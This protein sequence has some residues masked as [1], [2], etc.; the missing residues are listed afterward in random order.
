[1]CSKR[2][3]EASE[4]GL[5]LRGEAKKRCSKRRAPPIQ[6]SSIKKW[7]KTN[8]TQ[9]Q[10]WS[11]CRLAAGALARNAP[12]T[13][14]R[15]RRS[16]AKKPGAEL[17]QAQVTDYAEVYQVKSYSKKEVQSYG[18]FKSIGVLSTLLQR[19]ERCTRYRVKQDLIILS[20]IFFA[21]AR[22]TRLP[23]F[24]LCNILGKAEV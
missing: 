2:R 16:I 17:Y 4:E 20:C 9:G 7:T 24:I 23:Q 12:V 10:K 18:G 5:Q 15:R 1:M 6:R 3:G 19:I 11:S 8:L 21:R 13:E 14:K 22:C